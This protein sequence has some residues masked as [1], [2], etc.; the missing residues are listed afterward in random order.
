[1]LRRTLRTLFDSVATTSLQQAPNGFFFSR[2]IR[3]DR[4]FS[5][6]RVARFVVGDPL[7]RGPPHHFPSGSVGRIQLGQADF[8]LGDEYPTNLRFAS[9]PPNLVAIGE[10]IDMILERIAWAC[11]FAELGLV[12]RHEKR[13]AP[14]TATP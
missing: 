4:G 13:E 1:V 12:D 14:A 5:L 7:H 8:S 9:V 10:L 11:W 3:P 2:V 6:R